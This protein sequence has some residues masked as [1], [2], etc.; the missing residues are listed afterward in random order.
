MKLLKRRSTLKAAIL[1]WSSTRWSDFSSKSKPAVAAVNREQ[2]CISFYTEQNQKKKISKWIQTLKRMDSTH[3]R[4]QLSLFV[5]DRD[6]VCFESH[7]THENRISFYPEYYWTYLLDC[8]LV[9]HGS[10]AAW[11]FPSNFQS[12]CF[13]T[14]RNNSK[15]DKRGW[16]MMCEYLSALNITLV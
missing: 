7:A 4:L 6:L 14:R 3:F 10:N 13:V 8:L 2:P 15:V 9:E 16:Q 5:L 12:M 11:G 1:P